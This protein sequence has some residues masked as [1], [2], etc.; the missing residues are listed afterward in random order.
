MLEVVDERERLAHGRQQD[1]AARLV[2]LGLDREP[3]VVALVEDVRAEQVERLL[4]AVEGGP[5]VLGRA[6][7][8]ALAAAPGDV[9]LGA[10]FG[11]EVD[12]AHCLGEREPSY[13][14]V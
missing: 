12:V 4:V 6:R 11:G 9:D 10:Q 13:V 2:R 14:A 5:Y 7:F 3:E 1:V 8:G